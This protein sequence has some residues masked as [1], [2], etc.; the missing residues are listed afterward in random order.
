MLGG[1]IQWGRH[2]EVTF[3][4]FDSGL[5]TTIKSNEID[6][7]NQVIGDGLRISFEY[8]KSDDQGYDTPNGKI[9]I[10][11]LT[12]KTF[13]SLGERLRAEIEVKAGYLRSKMNS[14]KR[15]FYAVLMDKKYEMEGGL[16]V[17]TFEVLGD[18]IEKMIAHKMSMNLPKPTLVEIMIAITDNM[19]KGFAMNLKGT[20]EENEQMA[21]YLQKWRVSPY[22]Y[23]FANTPQQ[24]LKR[25]KDSF[26]ITYRMEKDMVVFSIMDSW[27]NW[28]L[29][30]AKQISALQKAQANTALVAENKTA[31]ETKDTKPMDKDGKPINLIK[32]HALVLS[33]DTGLVGTPII[34]TMV[35]DKAYDSALAEGEEV[36]S[37]KEQRVLKDKKTGEVK[38]DKKTGEVKMSKKPKNMKVARRTVVAKC[39]INSMLD[40]NA[41]VSIKT[42]SAICDGVYR[43]R[44]VKISGDTDGSDW[45]MELELNE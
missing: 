13:N 28:H 6:E 7:N 27:Y 17:A 35:V 34:K 24:E 12:E 44:S 25:L 29:D 31:P 9:V 26:G 20:D 2:A 14:P 42:E 32:T 10:Y 1:D 18:F 39:L 22:G 30:G 36:W 23:S 5:V 21:E 4:N 38:K 3:T 8:S 37:K 19:Q 33:P 40:F 45:Y 11:G 41:Q 15:I 43:V 16:S